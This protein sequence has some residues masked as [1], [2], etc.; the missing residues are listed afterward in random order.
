ME[1]LAPS[2]RERAVIDRLAAIASR[3]R[4]LTFLEPVPVLVQSRSEILRHL[5]RELEEEDL[6]VSRRV[7]VALGL[8]PADLDVRDLFERVLGEQVA[9]YYDP[10]HDQLVIRDEV[11]RRLGGQ[12]TDEAQVTIVHELVH[13][14]QDQRLGLGE[15]LDEELPS[16]ASSALQAVVEGDAT[17]AMLAYVLERQGI[18]LRFFTSQPERLARFASDAMGS[19][20]DPELAGAPA[21]LRVTLLSSYLDGLLFAAL[22]HGRGGWDAVDQAHR[23]P[24]VSTEQILHPERYLAGERPD[25]VRVPPLPRVDGAGYRRFEDDTLGELEMRVYFGQLEDSVHEA[26][27]DGWSG[28]H[29]V[30]YEREETVAIVWFSAWDDETEAEEAARAARAVQPYGG[31]V[32]TQGRGVGIVRHLDSN[33]LSEVAGAFQSFARSL[34]ASPPRGPTSD[35]FGQGMNGPRRASTVDPDSAE[36]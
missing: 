15:R 30:A 22:L 5:F 35:R 28:D 27:A 20:R 10:D 23:T 7:Y 14:L 32:W 6:E 3:S 13:A 25:E 36:D 2:S 16:D 1:G 4:E 9:G 33:L 34:P 29:L 17:L 31:A 11:M 18:P 24:P 8:L 21:I 12:D 26:A 19:S